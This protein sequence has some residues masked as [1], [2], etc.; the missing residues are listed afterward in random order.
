MERRIGFAGCYS[1]DIILMLAKVFCCMEKKVLIRDCNRHHILRASIPIPDS[2]STKTEEAEYDGL[3]FTEHMSEDITGN[4]EIELIDFGMEAG[5][6]EEATCTDWIVVTDMLLHH[7]KRLEEAEVPK[8]KVR[9]CVVRDAFE[10]ICRK[11]PAVRRYL[12]SVPDAAKFFISPDFRDVRNRYV[13]ETTHVYSI[14]RAS[15]EMQDMIYEIAGMFCTA[16]SEK[17]IRRR[18]KRAE[19]RQ[20]R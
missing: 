2:I 15:P 20:Y 19:R 14:S 10:E 5:N 9:V 12:D 17:E 3:F 18:V 13:C 1:H 4:Y 16:F 7:I 11:E 6:G 8:D